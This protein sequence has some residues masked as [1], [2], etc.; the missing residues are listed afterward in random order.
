M[1]FFAGVFEYLYVSLDLQLI[2]G[3][4]LAFGDP[5]HISLELSGRSA[6]GADVRFR[7]GF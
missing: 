6:P 1:E 2:A 4:Y 3:D 7:R 5:N